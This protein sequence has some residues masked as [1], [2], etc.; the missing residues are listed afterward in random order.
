MSALSTPTHN[1]L[2]QKK[3]KKK[4][5]H[6]THLNNQK[7]KKSQKRSFEMSKV[8]RELKVAKCSPLKRM[9]TQTRNSPLSP[10]LKW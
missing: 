8:A 6:K 4:E 10:P 2:E 3:K 1:T 7:L 5:R 9:H